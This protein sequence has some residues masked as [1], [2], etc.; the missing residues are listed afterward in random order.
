M[1]D[2][3]A[4]V[5]GDA[6]V[7][8]NPAL[9]GA[10][11][12]FTFGGIDVLRP[13][14]DRSPE[15]RAHACYPLVPYSNR[16]AHARLEFEGRVHDLAR[17]FGDHP[18][19]IHGVGWQRPWAIAANDATSMLL[20][21]DHKPVG[22]AARSW[23]WPMRATQS[24]SLFVDPA[25][26]ML[27]LTLTIANPG[28]VAF[29][30]GLGWHPFFVRSATTRLGFRAVGVWETDS[31]CLPTVH[32][33]GPTTRTFEPPREPGDATIDNVFT[34]WDGEATIVDADRR[35][36]ITLRA[37]RA[38]GF[39][40]VYA[41]E[42]KALLALEPVTH[43]TDAFNRASRGERDTGM[44]LLGPG[45]EFSCTMQIGARVLP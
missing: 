34:G 11:A 30:F 43:M 21:F 7:E 35:I 18:H 14:P 8:V 10:L 4:L 29:P 6:R 41:P 22:D 39:L 45:S 25:G 44:R 31:S 16:I 24:L 38:A 1:D 5:A 27:A 20:T 15:V 26:A 42:E 12:S 2:R 33:V 37:D 23:P 17:N 40:V 13:T 32:T 9:G 28:A 3:I 36:A 19:A